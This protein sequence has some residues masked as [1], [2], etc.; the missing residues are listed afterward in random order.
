MIAAMSEKIIL[1]ASV[2]LGAAG[3]IAWTDLPSAERA[4]PRAATSAPVVRPAAS[5]T[6]P[7]VHYSGC[8][9]VRALGKAPL[10]SDQPGY[11]AD[12][13]GDG[14]GIACEPHRRG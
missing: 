2:I 9:V 8:N 13:D 11:R 14:D 12:M 3:G 5:A 4:S 6:G 1:L 10:Y 7:D